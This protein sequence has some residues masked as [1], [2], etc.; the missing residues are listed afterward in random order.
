MTEL[1]RRNT[2]T[3]TLKLYQNNQIKIVNYERA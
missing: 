2:F 1:L 3:F